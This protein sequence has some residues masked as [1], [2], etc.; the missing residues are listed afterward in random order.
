MDLKSYFFYETIGERQSVHSKSSDKEGYKSVV[1]LVDASVTP[2]INVS[3]RLIERGCAAEELRMALP[4]IGMTDVK[5]A[6]GEYEHILPNWHY[7]T[8]Y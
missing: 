6:N 8:S 2:V 5:Q 4:A 3:S 1:D 7:L